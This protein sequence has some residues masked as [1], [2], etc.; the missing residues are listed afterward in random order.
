[1]ETIRWLWPIIILDKFRTTIEYNV[2]C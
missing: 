2:W 1:M